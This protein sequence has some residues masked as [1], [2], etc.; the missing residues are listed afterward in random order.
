[1]RTCALTRLGELRIVREVRMDKA[2][3]LIQCGIEF[4][5]ARKAC[6]LV[7]IV[8]APFSLQSKGQLDNS[9]IHQEILQNGSQT[10]VLAYSHLH[11]R[12]R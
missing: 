7:V 4:G 3:L 5:V 12:S 8:V 11:T 6:L 1:M 2:S 10:L 9:I